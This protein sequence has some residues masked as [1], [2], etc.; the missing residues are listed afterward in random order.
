MGH[1][2]FPLCS[3]VTF[4]VESFLPKVGLSELGIGQQETDLVLAGCDMA[5]G[6]GCCRCICWSVYQHD[7]VGR[8]HGRLCAYQ[9]G[10]CVLDKA[11]ICRYKS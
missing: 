2:G 5:H 3:F 7:C 8:N 10:N 6:R 4:V 11:Q 1:E 9:P